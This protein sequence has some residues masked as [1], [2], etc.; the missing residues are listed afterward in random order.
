MS[1]NEL[2]LLA[3]CF[4]GIALLYASVGFGGGSSYLALLALVV[5]DVSFV[6][7]TA[8]LCNLVVVSGSVLW[9]YRDQHLSLSYTLPFVLFSVPM[10]YLGAL[11]RLS[12][13]AFYVLL[14]ITLILA[15]GLLLGRS[16]REVST[17]GQRTY[18]AYLAGLV[19]G[20]IGLLSGLVGIGGGIFLAPLLHYLRW[21]RP[22]RIAALASC[23][24]L[25]N[26]L[27]GL[28]GFASAGTLRWDATETLPLL[29]AVLIG[30][31]FGIRLSL[32]R[33]SGL[34]IRRVTALL[35]LIV[36]VRMLLVNGLHYSL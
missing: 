27:A 33:W 6:R 9:Y 13:Q 36:G 25:V 28:A 29:A 20:T 11:F 12:E 23:F 18:P 31:Q 4:L 26:S 14:G 15:A 24:I 34:W 7:S 8:L 10:T 19:G 30:G 32:R 5:A 3:A 22:V 35:V 21:G 17:E 1:S 16:F 2:I